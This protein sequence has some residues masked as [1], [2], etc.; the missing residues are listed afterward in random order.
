LFGTLLPC[1]STTSFLTRD[2]PEA[3]WHLKSIDHDPL[4]NARHDE[5]ASGLNNFEKLHSEK[6]KPTS[7]PTHVFRVK[8]LPLSTD[9]NG[10]LVSHLRL[11]T[12]SPGPIQMAAAISEKA[13]QYWGR[14]LPPPY[15]QH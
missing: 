13:K 12:R 14:Y 2:I 15:G 8:F 5:T 11:M 10:P 9:P 1:P 3:H 6:F 7:A 4:H